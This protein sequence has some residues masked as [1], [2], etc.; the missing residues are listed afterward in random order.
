M[1]EDD[2][3]TIEANKYLTWDFFVDNE[4]KHCLVI[5]N[6]K[7]LSVKMWLKNEFD[8]LIDYAKEQYGILVK[9]Q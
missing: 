8:H 9:E 6:E 5:Q 4:D 1:D 7:V 3:S 2:K